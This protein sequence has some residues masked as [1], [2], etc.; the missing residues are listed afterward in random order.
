MSN[1]KKR[2]N[3]LENNT[4]LKVFSVCIALLFWVIVAMTNPDDYQQ[5]FR[6]IEVDT[7]PQ[8]DML[9]YLGLDTIEITPNQV[10]AIVYG[11]LSEVS[12]LTPEDLKATIEI[13][14]N[15]TQGGTYNLNLIQANRSSESEYRVE[16]SPK[17]V[18]VRL[19]RLVQKSFDVEAVI[20]GLSVPSGFILDERQVITPQKM[21]ISGPQAELDRIARCVI[22]VEFNK[23]LENTHADEYPVVLLDAQGNVINPAERHLTL[24][25]ESVQLV[26]T[27]LREKELPLLVEFTNIPRSF[28]VGEFSYSMSSY[29]IMV[30]GPVDMVGRYQELVSGF[31]D[32]RS[33]TPDNKSF[34]FPVEMPSSKIINLDGTT[35][36]TLSFNTSGWAEERF[37]VQNIMLLNEPARFSVELLNNTLYDVEIVG[38]ETILKGITADDIIA[39]VDLS[40]RDLVEGQ[41]KYPVK[42]SIPGKGLVWAAGEYSV[43]IHA[44]PF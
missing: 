20:T 15:L 13:P 28:P 4:Y 44:S 16:Y 6:N 34:V 37:T 38:D 9:V 29:E 18:Q 8:V 31:I 40:D 42:I 3:L 41:Q 25:A 19:D 12:R 43:V 23:P 33:V 39:E 35:E 21:D 32:V 1:G 11:G 10:D 26:I 14:Y 27:V 5:G 17:R 36:V 30:A 7:E 22:N 2:K 24:G